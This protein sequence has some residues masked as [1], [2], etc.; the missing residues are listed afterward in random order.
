MDLRGMHKFSGR[1][2]EMKAVINMPRKT[3][4]ISDVLLSAACGTI[5]AVSVIP[6]SLIALVVF[7]VAAFGATRARVH[8]GRTRFATANF[9]ISILIFGGLVGTAWAYRPTKIE[10][11]LLWR[12]IKLPATQMTLAD[13]CYA[14]AYDRQ[15][16]P[17]TI[18]FCFADADKETLI[19][20]QRQNVTL[21]EFLDAIESQSVLRRRFMHCGNGYT[22]LHGGDCTFGLYVRDPKLTA[23]RFDVDSYAANRNPRITAR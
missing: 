4:S 22:I 15:V 3:F 7:G 5:T 14:A 11:Q 21:S 20:W 13:L 1:V 9:L 10:E 12:E 18:S 6:F 8:S 16:F 17:I 2:F 19:K 23:P